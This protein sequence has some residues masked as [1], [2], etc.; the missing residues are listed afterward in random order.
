[1]ALLAL[2]HRK[3]QRHKVILRFLL[4]WVQPLVE[5]LIFQR[6]LLI[7]VKVWRNYLKILTDTNQQVRNAC[8]EASGNTFNV[9]SNGGTPSNPLQSV[10]PSSLWTDRR[11]TP[12][13]RQQQ[14]QQE[15]LSQPEHPIHEAQGWQRNRQGHLS[16]YSAAK[17]QFKSQYIARNCLADNQGEG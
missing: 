14:T 13:L 3:A 8:Y 15:L 7:Q 5:L 11:P 16:F 4:S 6:L 2:N 10:L 12:S 1:M 17:K 9:A